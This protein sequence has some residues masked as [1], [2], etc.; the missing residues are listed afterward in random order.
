MSPVLY[1]SKAVIFPVNTT[2]NDK[3]G[4]AS[5]FGMEMHADQ[6]IQVL[7]SDIIMD[8]V[9]KYCDP[10]GSRHFTRDYLRNTISMYRN[11]WLSIEVSAKSGN[12][13]DA[14]C[15]VQHVIAHT[16]DAYNEVIRQATIPLMEN[17]KSVYF[18][19]KK[20]LEMLADSFRVIS[21]DFMPDDKKILT[22]N[23]LWE[24]KQKKVLELESKYESLRTKAEKRFVPL[25][26]LNKPE[27]PVHPLGKN[28]VK[29]ILAGIVL[30][31]FAVLSFLTVRYQYLYW[32]YEGTNIS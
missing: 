8:S 25:F 32:K 26:V 23:Q 10:D 21:G 17:A 5:P 20:E 31:L 30:M 29:N 14:L 13:E 11:Q 15:I 9:R 2:D 24:A 28:Y 6:L 3:L 7:R 1:E 12:P 27:L 22:M 19:H 18:T 4:G 16:N